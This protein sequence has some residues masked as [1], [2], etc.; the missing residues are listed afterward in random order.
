MIVI[1][2]LEVPVCYALTVWLLRPL[3]RLSRAARRIA[4]GNMGVRAKVESDDEVG[5]LTRDFN[6]M[7]DH[8]E[9]QVDDIKRIYAAIEATD[10]QDAEKIYEYL[11]AGSDK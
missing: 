7:A 8:L 3:R 4:G 5:Q 1:L 6:R 10:T 11:T 9:Q 2:L